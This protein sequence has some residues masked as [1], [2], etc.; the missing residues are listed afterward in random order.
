MPTGFTP[1]ILN[2]PPGIHTI[3]S[4]REA[5]RLFLLDIVSLKSLPPPFAYSALSS[6]VRPLIVQ[7]IAFAILS[8]AIVAV[9]VFWLV[10]LLQRIIKISKNVKNKY[11]KIVLNFI[12]VLFQ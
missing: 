9:T 2:S 7:E 6:G 5:G 1:P 12:E 11:A 4:G 10:L 8:F 3:A